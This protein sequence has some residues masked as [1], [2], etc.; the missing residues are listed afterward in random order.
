MFLEGL[1]MDIS[2]LQRIEEADMVLVGIG[3][4]FDCTKLLKQNDEY[5]EKC[6]LLE[7]E[8]RRWLLP[9]LNQQYTSD[10]TQ[11]N[12][13]KALEKLA[14]ILKDKNYFVVTTSTNPVVKDI[15]WKEHRLVAPC[16]S[17]HM[18]QC[19][20]GCA[21]V[22]QETSCEDVNEAK[23][24]LDCIGQREKVEHLLGNCSKCGKPLVFNN[25]YAPEYNENGYIKQWELYTKWL[26]GSLNKK[27]MILELGVNMQFPSVIRFPF[28]KVAFFN[29]KAFMY[30]VNEKLY[31]LSEE[32]NGKGMPISENAVDWLLKE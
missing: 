19:S 8:E 15:S 6:Q 2:V 29:Q 12:I 21:D 20:N 22:L 24:M 26:Q 16:G 3:E 32:L 13:K 27:L 10:E 9:L 23:K 11:E 18:K 31:F 1:F 7:A 14:N 30:R 25:I 4:E 28:E 5:K 17:Y